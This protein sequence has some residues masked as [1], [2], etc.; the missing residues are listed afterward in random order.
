MVFIVC[1]VEVIP[2]ELLAE[3]LAYYSMSQWVWKRSGE[4]NNS[5]Y[6]T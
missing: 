4:I 3:S 1:I 6:I 2:K 5:E